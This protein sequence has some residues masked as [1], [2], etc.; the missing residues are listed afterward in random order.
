M[1]PGINL[2]LVQAS[3]STDEAPLTIDGQRDQPLRFWIASPEQKGNIPRVVAAEIA[4]LLVAKTTIGAEKIRPSEIAVLVMTNAETADIQKAL[5]QF[6]IP[7]VVYSAASVFESREVEELLRVLLA[8]A[9]PTREKI[10]RAALAT[11]LADFK[12]S[13]LEKLFASRAIRNSGATR[14]S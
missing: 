1:I 3:G 14:V 2:V 12:A 5:S 11:E 9:E 10:V 6:R 7:S 4:R 13:E 8:V